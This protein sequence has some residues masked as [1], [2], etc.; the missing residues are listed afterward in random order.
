MIMLTFLRIKIPHEAG[1]PT[2]EG[3]S[4]VGRRKSID[5]NRG[6]IRDGLAG[7]YAK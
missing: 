7:S 5:A 2:R 6:G 3:W 4:T 1:K